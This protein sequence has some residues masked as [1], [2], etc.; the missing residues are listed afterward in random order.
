[1]VEQIDIENDVDR[2][3]NVYLD[4]VSAADSLGYVTV[5]STDELPSPASGQGATWCNSELSAECDPYRAEAT[6]AKHEATP[7]TYDLIQHAIPETEQRGAITVV[8]SR[9]FNAVVVH[10]AGASIASMSAEDAATAIGSL[11]SRLFASAAAS[12]A[13]APRPT[14]GFTTGLGL[15]PQTMPS[16]DARADA[17]VRGDDLVFVTYRV[18]PAIFGGPDPRAWFA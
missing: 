15:H 4:V 9:I 8:E 2:Y 3:I 14:M 18:S 10:G 16:A 7:D 12:S 11:A 5:A 13:W 6:H 1:M 17:I